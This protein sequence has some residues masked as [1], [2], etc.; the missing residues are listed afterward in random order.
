M[1]LIANENVKET[2]IRTL[3]EEDSFFSFPQTRTD[4]HAFKNNPLD[5]H[6]FATFFY[7][8]SET[9]SHRLNENYDDDSSW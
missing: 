3:W 8:L 2:Q 4:I 5:R 6:E 7:V 9:L 1:T